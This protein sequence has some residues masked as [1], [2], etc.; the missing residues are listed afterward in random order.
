MNGG[1]AWTVRTLHAVRIPRPRWNGE[2]IH[3]KTIFVY[4][5]QGFGDAIQFVR[6][7]SVLRDRGARVIVEMPAGTDSALPL[8]D[9]RR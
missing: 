8:R 5:E 4:A 3:G 1:C 7:A 2:S 9:R 6:Y